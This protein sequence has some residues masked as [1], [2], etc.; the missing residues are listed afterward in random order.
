MA[1]GVPAPAQ[2]FAI[3]LESTGVVIAS[4][5]FGEQ[6]GIT[7]DLDDIVG[8]YL[9]IHPSPCIGTLAAV[10]SAIVGRTYIAQITH[11]AIGAQVTIV[12]GPVVWAD[13]A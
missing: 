3:F 4:S 8:T 10:F 2:H 5:E 13:L 11:P 6:V 7:V 1:I 9:T 12:S